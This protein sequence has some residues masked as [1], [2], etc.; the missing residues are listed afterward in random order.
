MR[1]LKNKY[2]NFQKDITFASNLRVLVFSVHSLR[3][4]VS[5]SK[6][7]KAFLFLDEPFDKIVEII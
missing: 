6:L 7:F 2:V 4:Y 5:V 3:I 1:S